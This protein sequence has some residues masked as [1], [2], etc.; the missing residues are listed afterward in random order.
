M[1]KTNTL[2]SEQKLQGLFRP[3]EASV[4]ER[5]Q[6]TGKKRDSMNERVSRGG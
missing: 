1:K 6:G 5:Q 3:L 4:P 2:I